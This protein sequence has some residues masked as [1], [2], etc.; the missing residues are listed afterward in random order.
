M[1]RRRF[2][3]LF[4]NFVL[5]V[6]SWSPCP[7][8]QPSDFNPWLDLSWNSAHAHVRAGKKA[9]FQYLWSW[10]SC[11]SAGWFKPWYLKFSF[12]AEKQFRFSTYVSVVFR[13]LRNLDGANFE[14][15]K[16]A[17]KIIFTALEWMRKQKM[18]PLSTS[19]AYTYWCARCFG[20]RVWVCSQ[21]CEGAS[22]V[23]V[24]VLFEHACVLL[25]FVC[26]A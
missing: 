26:V 4:S 2:P 10:L 7:M 20:V 5:L 25:G 3:C 14:I 18:R 16:F 19:D 8:Y 12:A 23:C 21:S 13:F 17:E 1:T 6:P 24:Y 15:F 11:Y 9:E 22:V